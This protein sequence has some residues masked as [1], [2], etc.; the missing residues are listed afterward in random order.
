MEPLSD[1]KAAQ[2]TFVASAAAFVKVMG[3]LPLLT[4]TATPQI[5]ALVT[6][7]R[8]AGV[9]LIAQSC[10]TGADKVSMGEHAGSEVAAVLAL[11]GWSLAPQQPTP[12]DMIK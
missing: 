2:T 3:Q 9:A 10:V 11:C 6:K 7:L 12:Y 8:H 5:D 4:A 1:A